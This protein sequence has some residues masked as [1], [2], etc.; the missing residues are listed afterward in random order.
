MLVR[1][2]GSFVIAVLIWGGLTS[3]GDGEFFTG[4]MNVFQYHLI[5]KPNPA[6][7]VGSFGHEGLRFVFYVIWAVLFVG[8]MKK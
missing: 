2:V 4:V 6:W 3:I 1:L 8:S 7:N 5:F